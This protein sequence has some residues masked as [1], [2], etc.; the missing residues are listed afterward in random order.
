MLAFLDGSEG[1]VLGVEISGTYTKNDVEE[2]KKAFE[3]CLKSGD[4]VNVLIKIDG[5]ERESAEL[6]ALLEYSRYAKKN[7]DKFGHI[8]IVG[9]SRFDRILVKMDNIFVV[10]D[11]KKGREE[12]YFDV[13]EIDKA[14][15]F[16]RG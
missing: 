14:W 12:R 9:H 4:K 3:G 8:A 6:G 13:S 15:A 1:N 7:L 2:F 16:V 10:A 11:R 5:L